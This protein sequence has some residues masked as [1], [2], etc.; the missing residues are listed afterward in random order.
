[1]YAIRS[2]YAGHFLNEL[3]KV[4]YKK[5][6]GGSKMLTNYMIEKELEHRT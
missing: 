3:V 2:Y 6:I 5:E 1:M 4:V